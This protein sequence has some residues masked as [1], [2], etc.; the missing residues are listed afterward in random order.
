MSLS[1]KYWMLILRK[2]ISAIYYLSR[3]KRENMVASIEAE[4]F[5]KTQ[6]PFV[7]NNSQQTRRRRGFRNQ[8]EVAC[9]PHSQRVGRA[10]DG[11]SPQHWGE[12]RSLT[13][14]L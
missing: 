9:K 4:A 13:S 1:Q 3:L 10:K 14:R 5:V 8:M 6:H 11:C 2:L 12:A 7:I